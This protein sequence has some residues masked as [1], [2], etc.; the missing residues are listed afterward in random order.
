LSVLVGRAPNTLRKQLRPPVALP[1]LPRLVHIGTPAD[2]LRRRPDIRAAERR[3]AAATARIGLVTAGLF[4]RVSFSGE[5]GFVADGLDRAGEYATKTYSYGPGIH[6]AAFDL[7]RVQARIGQAEAQ[8]DGSLAGYE[9]TVLRALEETENA[10]VSYGHAR[11]QLGYLRAS[12]DASNR[13]A[14]LAHARFEAGSSDFLDVLDA[15]RT[16]LEADARLAQTRTGVATSLVALYKS[17]GGSWETDGRGTASA[18]G[19]LAP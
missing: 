1:P 8:A 17:L 4:P 6:W 3:L 16:Q 5:I 13:A 11:R 18:R 9:Q 15:E 12:A 7:G 10:L 19:A 2:L 14:A